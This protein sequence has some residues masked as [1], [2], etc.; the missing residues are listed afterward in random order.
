[1]TGRWADEA[2]RLPGADERDG[3]GGA[4]LGTG[5]MLRASDNWQGARDTTR[6]LI[7]G[8]GAVTAPTLAFPRK[9]GAGATIRAPLRTDIAARPQP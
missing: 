9:R 2:A 1:M 4:Q 5:V 7:R 6:V 3:F 8:R